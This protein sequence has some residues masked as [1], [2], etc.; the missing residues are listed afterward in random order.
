MSLNMSSRDSK[1]SHREFN[2]S[3]KRRN[4]SE[5]SSLKKKNDAFN[6]QH[7]GEETVVILYYKP[8]GVITSHSNQDSVSLNNLQPQEQDGRITVYQDVMS[9]KGFI[10][11]ENLNKS[12]SQ[13]TGIHS[14]FHA[15]G[16]LDVD[17]TGLLLLTNDGGLVHHVTNPNSATAL[18]QGKIVKVYD[19][20]IMGYHTLDPELETST[21]LLQLSKGVDIGKK[22]GGMTLPPNELQVLNHPSSKTTLVR[23]A[24][25]EGK[26]RQVRRMFHAIGS[27]VIQLHRR[28]V[29]NIDLDMLAMGSEDQVAEGSWR[30]LTKKEIM[31]GLNWKVRPLVDAKKQTSKSNSNNRKSGNKRRR[32]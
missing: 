25:S 1:R 31:N 28:Q 13:V 26:N 20:L 27:G 19:A 7:K 17:T 3:S 8:K 6:G 29:G 15:I 21:K 14:K 4:H 30:L 11:A 9:M 23:I 10:N 16:R 24:I 32:R 2:T 22:Y 5:F 12:F 18:D